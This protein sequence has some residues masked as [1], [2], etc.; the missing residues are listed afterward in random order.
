MTQSNICFDTVIPILNV[1]NLAASFDYY[2]NKLGFTKEWDH[3]DPPD[4]G[5]MSRG[6]SRIFVCQGALGQPGMW[7]AIYVTDI[8]G[9]YEEYKN[10]GAMILDPP[11]NMS[12]GMRVMV[13]GDP[14]GHRLRLGCDSVGPVDESNF[15]RAE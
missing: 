6:D 7:L 1:Q 11:T 3:G 15:H 5:C 12:F 9:L 8:D 10:T 13:V 4:F 2:V 14:D